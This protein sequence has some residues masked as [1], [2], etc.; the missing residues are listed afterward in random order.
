MKTYYVK[1]PLAGIISFSIEAESEKEAI[2]KA[3]KS[4]ITVDINGENHPEIEEWDLYEKIVEG[5]VVY[6]PLWRPEAFEE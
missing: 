1:V 2:N 6:A 5:N 3:L 4:D